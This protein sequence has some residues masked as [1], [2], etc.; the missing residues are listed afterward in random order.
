MLCV[1]AAYLDLREAKEW[2]L[3]GCG[4]C[5]SKFEVRGDFVWM[6]DMC[7]CV[8]GVRVCVCGSRE[9]SVGFSLS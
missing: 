6:S 3:F 7:L 9:G 1:K 8:F 5:V 2:S 4:L